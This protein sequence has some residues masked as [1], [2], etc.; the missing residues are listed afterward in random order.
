LQ[1]HV[2]V[3]AVRSL[4]VLIIDDDDSVRDLLVDFMWSLGH[5]PTTARDGRE[6]V[7]RFESD[8]PEI[9]IT[10]LVMPGLS[11]W[12]VVTLI[13]GIDAGARIIV[14]SGGATRADVERAWD[15][16]VPLLHKPVR[17]TELETALDR[18]TTS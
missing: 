14:I 5:E 9:V 11:G 4:K 3:C 8:R 2:A 7:A 17:L 18:L 13:R 6:G 1:V 16:A 15:E 10:D 12:E